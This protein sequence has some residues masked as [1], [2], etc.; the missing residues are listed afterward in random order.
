MRQLCG[1]MRAERY[2][3]SLPIT[4]FLSYYGVLAIPKKLNPE[5]GA[6]RTNIGVVTYIYN[7]IDLEL[8]IDLLPQGEFCTL[9]LKLHDT[10]NKMTHV[11]PLYVGALTSNVNV[12]YS[13]KITYSG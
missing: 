7:F 13:T 12:N 2:L 3:T 8:A 10:R 9:F 4:C 5:T 6:Y 11:S 1:S